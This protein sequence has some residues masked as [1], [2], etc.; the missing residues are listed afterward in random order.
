MTRILIAGNTC[1]VGYA[2][3]RSLQGLG[4]IIA[5]D[6]KQMDLADLNQGVT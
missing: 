5:V 6:R 3:E 2:L 1:Q 4:E